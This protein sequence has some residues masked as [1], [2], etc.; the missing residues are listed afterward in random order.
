MDEPNNKTKKL[1][2]GYLTKNFKKINDT[3]NEKQE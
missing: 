1:R 3:K 2:I